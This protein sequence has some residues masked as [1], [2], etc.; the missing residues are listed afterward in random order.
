MAEN[1]KYFMLTVFPFMIKNG[2]G[3]ILVS[4]ANGTYYYA[5][6][7]LPAPKLWESN[8]RFNE[9]NNCSDPGVLRYPESAIDNELRF[10]LSFLARMDW[11]PRLAYPFLAIR[12]Q[13]C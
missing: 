8:S 1:D 11:P 9:I 7:W 10:L 3:K 6:G 4:F 12:L 13:H 2:A 5:R